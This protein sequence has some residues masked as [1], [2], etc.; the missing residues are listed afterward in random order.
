[1]ENN[2][3]F[4]TD[5]IKRFQY[6]IY[7]TCLSYLGNEDDAKDVVQEICIIIWEKWETFKGQSSIG[8]WIFRISVNACL[9]HKRKNKFQHRLPIDSIPDFSDDSFNNDQSSIEEEK[10]KLLYQSIKQL[11]AFDRMMIILYLNGH[12]YEQISDILGITVNNVGVRINRIRTKIKLNINFNH[13][14]IK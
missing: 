1:M 3:I 12:K 8:T 6:K 4:I 5:V 7:A 11:N 9:M 2:K 14:K 13:E 10:F